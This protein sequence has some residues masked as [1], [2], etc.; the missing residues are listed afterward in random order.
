MSHLSHFY[1]ALEI[2]ETATRDEIKRAYRDLAQIWHPDKFEHNPRLRAK[3]AE[4]FRLILEAYKCLTS[5]DFDLP[6]ELSP[7]AKPDV[8]TQK[9]KERPE[10]SKGSENAER[11]NNDLDVEAPELQKTATS[12]STYMAFGLTILFLLLLI[13]SVSKNGN[14]SSQIIANSASIQI[15]DQSAILLS[16]KVEIDRRIKFKDAEFDRLTGWYKRGI[17]VAE[18]LGYNNALAKIRMEEDAIAK[19]IVE[20]NEKRRSMSKY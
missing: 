14:S 15:K 20:Y 6:Q 19:L 17:L 11:H 12:W 18:E 7:V 2:S 16:M 4:K 3:A 10:A 5:G 1:E 13:R 9:K 8:D